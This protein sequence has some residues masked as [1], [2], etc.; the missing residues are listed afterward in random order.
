MR[1]SLIP[2][3]CLLCACENTLD[4]PNDGG[5]G[6]GKD[7]NGSGNGG[8]GGGTTI[9]DGAG[10]GSGSGSGGNPADAR[11]PLFVAQGQLGRTAVS[12]D[13][14]RTWVGERRS[15]QTYRWS[16]DPKTA[17]P[18]WHEIPI[19]TMSCGSNDGLLLPEGFNCDH[20]AHPARGV[21]FGGGTVMTTFGWGEPGGIFTSQDGETWKTVLEGTT[22]GGLAYVQGAWIAGGRSARRSVDGGETW[23]EPF[24]TSLDSWNVRRVGQTE[25]FGGRVILLGDNSSAVVSSDG[26]ETWWRPDVYPSAC[27]GSIQNEGGIVS[28]GDVWLIVG[29]DGTVCKSTDGGKVWSQSSIGK[30]PSSHVVWNGSVFQ[31]WSRGTLHTSV[32]GQ[33]WTTQSI[34]PVDLAIGAVASDERGGLAAMLGGWDTWDENQKFYWSDDG[35]TW[36]LASE[37]E[38]NDPMRTIAFGYGKKPESCR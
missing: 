30:E 27:G 25:G 3:L 2:V 18:T 26:G 12:C 31:A 15:L 4:V 32:D 24:D 13:G 22:F 8:S 16:P 1:R 10:A 21:L 9:A 33:S 6:G 34:T 37:F 23:S 5:V 29:G 36:Q 38:R 7:G 20:Y 35:L 28:N 17:D 11:Y 14:G 19:A